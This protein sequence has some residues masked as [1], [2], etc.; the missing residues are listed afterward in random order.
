MNAKQRK[1]RQFQ[2]REAEIIA[3][4]FE[5]FRKHDLANVTIEQI[6]TRADIGKGTV[7]KH[8]KSKD[9]IYT[10]ILIDL[11]HTMRAEITSIDAN[12]NFRNRLDRIIEI[13]WRH[14]MRDSKFLQ[15]LNQH[16][17]SGEFRKN[18]GAKLLQKFDALQTEDTHFYTQLLADAQARGEIIK[19]PLDT[20]LFCVTAAIDGAILVYW[21]ME[22][23]S[24]ITAKDGSKFLKALQNFTY[25]ALCDE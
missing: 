2:L 1:A 19:Q 17:M 22:S 9:E 12:L 3:A 23:R 20:L 15:Q 25:R 16:L 4:A 10:H 8:F 5:L 24:E 7:Y 11:N 14:N 6:A 13:I 21:Q 18:L